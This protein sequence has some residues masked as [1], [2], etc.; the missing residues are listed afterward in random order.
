MKQRF[1][2][3]ALF[4]TVFTFCR[5][6]QPDSL[7]HKLDSLER[8]ADTSGQVNLTNPGLYNDTTR[9]TFPVYFTLLGSNLKQQ[10]IAPFKASKKDWGNV[11]KFAVVTGIVAF[12]DKPVQKSA[13]RWRQNSSVVRNVSE[14]VTEFGG[15]YE[16]YTLAALGAYGLVFKKEKMKTTTLLATQAYVT[17]SAVA[18]LVKMITGR[19]RPGYRGEQ[20]EAR[21]TFHG[22]FSL[23]GEKYRGGTIRSAFPSGHTA[24]AFAAATVFAMEYSDKPLVPI[25]AYTS[26]SLIGLSRITENKHWATDVVVGAMLGYLS[27]RQVVNNYHRYARIKRTQ[28][29]KAVSFGLNY[30]FGQ[31]MPMLVWKL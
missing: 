27:G 24:V 7:L 19:E 8:K 11:A 2:L 4:I 3:C 15:M 26:A 13:L 25:I 16:A 10:F 17:S 23:F 29:Q 9:I 21:G 20:V 6:Q 30:Q 14:V 5:A 22:P 31:V 1:F 18:M 28:K 12:A